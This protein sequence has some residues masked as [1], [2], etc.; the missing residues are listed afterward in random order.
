MVDGAFYQ[1]SY[2]DTRGYK[3]VMCIGKVNI[4]TKE[5]T[6]YPDGDDRKF[7]G[8]V[9]LPRIGEMFSSTMITTT[10]D[11]SVVML[12]INNCIRYPGTYDS[13]NS[14]I[15]TKKYRPVINVSSAV[16]ITGG[17]GTQDSPFEISL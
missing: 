12:P 11:D 14:S 3:G 9:G 5:C 15:F 2:G 6:R 16:K 17:N 7:V 10:G 1:G 13:C 4:P 8:K